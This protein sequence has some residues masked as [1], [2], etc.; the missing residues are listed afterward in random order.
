MKLWKIIGYI[1][2]LIGL[3][4]LTVIFWG[5]IA[6]VLFTFL[7]IFSVLMFPLQRFFVDDR[8]NDFVDDQNG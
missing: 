8:E 3:I 7:L 6:S 5:S 4:A 2:V 1:A